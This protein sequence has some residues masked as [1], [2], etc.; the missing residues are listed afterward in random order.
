MD[1]YFSGIAVVDATG[2]DYYDTSSQTVS[3]LYKQCDTAYKSGK[4]VLVTGW[5]F[6][7][8]V[9]SP[10]FVYLLPASNSYVIDGKISVSSVDVVTRL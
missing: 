5:D 6:N 4:V 10:M 3:G 9:M 2:F 8:T 7:G 1:S